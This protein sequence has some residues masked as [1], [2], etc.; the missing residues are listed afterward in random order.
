M[1]ETKGSSGSSMM[2]WKNFG[3][4]CTK[5]MTSK[6]AWNSVN[7]YQYLEQVKSAD[8]LIEVKRA[9]ERDLWSLATSMT[10]VNDGMPH[11]SGASDKVGNI[12]QKII[13]QQERINAQ[14]DRY[15][16]IRDDVIR[17]I[18]QLPPKQYTILHWL[19]VRKRE[20]RKPGQEWYYTWREVAENL[21]IT[22]QTVGNRR[23]RAVRNLQKILDAE[24]IAKID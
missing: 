13:A 23:R 22:E 4:I 7:A 12:I 20:R 14:I 11:A 21:G 2:L 18:E 1:T 15:I 16:D 6:R 24:E 5:P 9:E 8:A 19:Y 17:H 10:Q 3:K